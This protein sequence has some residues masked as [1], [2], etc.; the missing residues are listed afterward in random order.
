MTMVMVVML[1]L[2]ESNRVQTC[3]FVTKLVPRLE[4]SR[5]CTIVPKETCH[6]SFSR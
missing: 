1:V 4:P 3:R 5:Q 2:F 6:M